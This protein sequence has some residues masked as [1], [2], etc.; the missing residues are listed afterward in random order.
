MKKMLSL[1]AGAGAVRTVYDNWGDMT[2]QVVVFS[3]L[4]AWACISLW[5]GHD[6]EN[7]SRN[8]ER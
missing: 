4:C 2:I 7:N 1:L 6:D 8:H 5:E 3:L